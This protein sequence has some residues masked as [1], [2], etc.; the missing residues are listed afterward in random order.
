MLSNTLK[1]IVY[2]S[3]DRLLN[4]FKKFKKDSASFQPPI[5]QISIIDENGKFTL[6]DDFRKILT[7]EIRNLIMTILEESKKIHGI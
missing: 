3:F 1:N 4:F 6:S 5:L 2:Q 7:D